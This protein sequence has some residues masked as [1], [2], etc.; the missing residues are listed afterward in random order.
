MGCARRA[1]PSGDPVE[2]TGP[3][4]ERLDR[5]LAPTRQH[6]FFRVVRS[7][8]RDPPR[9]RAFVV[10]AGQTAWTF[11]DPSRSPDPTLYRGAFNNPGYCTPA[12]GSI[13]WYCAAAWVSTSVMSKDGR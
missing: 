12:R 11:P 4:L 8:L 10:G 5:A 9:L 6:G 7:P 1:A 13:A 2:S 3:R